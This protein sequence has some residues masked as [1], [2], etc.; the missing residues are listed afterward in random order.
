MS[1][2]WRRGFTLWLASITCLLIL[3]GQP[4]GL[5][6]AP[7]KQLLLGQLPLGQLP[8]TDLTPNGTGDLPKG[9]QRLGSIEVIAV[10]FNDTEL[11]KIVSPTVQDRAKP[12]NIV[13]VDV[14]A[15]QIEENLQLVAAHIE[16]DLTLA[17]GR[18]YATLFDPETVRVS[19]EIIDKQLV[20]VAKD[21]Q[22]PQSQV[23]MTITAQDAEF[24]GVSKQ[25]L[26]QR[27]RQKLQE[28]ISTALSASSPDAI[29]KRFERLLRWIAAVT[30]IGLTLLFVRRWLA[31]WSQRLRVL[32]GQRQSLSPSPALEVEDDDQAWQSEV[33]EFIKTQ[34]SFSQRINIIEFF[35]W[36]MLWAQILLWIWMIGLSLEVLPT[37]RPYAKLLLSLP[38]SLLLLWFVMGLLNRLLDLSLNRFAK[39]WETENLLSFED[40]QR[41]GLR[42]TTIVKVLRDLKTFVI[43][44]GGTIWFLGTLGIDT[45]SVIAVGA[46]AAF[47]ISL[48]FQNLIKDL[49]NGF[50]ILLEDQYALGDVV[51]I[52]SSSGTVENINLRITQLR[53]AE[54]RLITI[55]NSLIS[56]VE[57]QTRTWARVDFQVLVAAETDIHLAQEILHHT[58]HE[59]CQDP[60]WQPLILEPPNLLGVAELA[61]NGTKLHLQLKTQPHA[62]GHVERELRFRIQQAFSKQ[63]IQIGGPK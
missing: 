4:L 2:F 40:V 14:R 35:R 3:V 22:R 48:A 7:V 51:T 12:G 34:F 41:R 30:V 18:D 6:Q 39:V 37:T 31:S 47:A 36:L 28:T 8:L 59:L 57:N 52:G 29:Q 27:W 19:V 15:R 63:Q 25:E 61:A 54:G 55:P 46:V 42:I 20:L 49:L 45:N 23:L 62:K 58:A 11:F 43:Y 21:N 33:A 53:N 32:Q 26:A 56:Q 38:Y 24:Y 16:P 44:L 5:A 10:K 13:P 17:R 1:V 50:L 9:V 60:Q